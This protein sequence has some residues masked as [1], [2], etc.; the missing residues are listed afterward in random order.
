MF[1]WKVG[2][3]GG[4]GGVGGEGH[5]KFGKNKGLLTIRCGELEVVFLKDNNPSSEFAVNLPTAE[6]VLHRVGICD[7]FCSA[8][9]NVMA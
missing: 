6:Q 3:D 5:D 4:T 9:Q 1:I 7:D 8:K 2:V